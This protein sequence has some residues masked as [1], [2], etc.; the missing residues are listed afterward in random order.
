MSHN[1]KPENDEI[2]LAKAKKILDKG[3]CQGSIFDPRGILDDIPIAEDEFLIICT[4]SCTLVSRRFSIDPYAEAMIVKPLTEY[5]PRSEIATGKNQRKLQI[6][7]LDHSNFKCIECDINKR[8]FFD[9]N[10]LLEMYPLQELGIEERGGDKLAG[11]IGRAYT[12]IALPDLLVERMR[13]GLSKMIRKCLDKKY[14]DDQK[15]MIPLHESVPYIFIDWQPR[16]NESEFYEL[17]FIF[18][19]FDP[20]VEELLDKELIEKL[21]FYLSEPGKDGLR[22]SSLICRTRDATFV[23]D[24]DEHDRLSDWDFLSDLGDIVYAPPSKH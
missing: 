22:I 16:K 4:Q 2:D 18:L 19:C 24:L 8:F 23:S 12:R 20:K 13:L 10:R 14:I 7:L 6:E 21:E 3:W 11:W 5:N 17:R 9:R 1:S 15:N